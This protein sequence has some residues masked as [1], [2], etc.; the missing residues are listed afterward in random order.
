MNIEWQHRD[1]VNEAGI[2]NKLKQCLFHNGSLSFFLKEKCTGVFQVEPESESWQQPMPDEAESLSLEKHADVF[3]RESWLKSDDIR[4]V[5]ARTVIPEITA[6]AD[7]GRLTKLGAKPLGEIL[8]A[9]DTTH[10]ANVR[11]AII[12]DD[13]EL[14]K[15]VTNDIKI[16]EEIWGRQSL[17]FMQNKPLLISEVFLPSLT[18][19]IQ[20]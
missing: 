2:N 12:P 1:S 10:R 8:F 17:F 5:Y 3:I 16:T 20:D 9:D 18:T 6:A 19:C 14:Y 7:N 11:Y 4:L 15:L 13:C